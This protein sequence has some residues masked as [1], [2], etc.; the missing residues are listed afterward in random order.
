MRIKKFLSYYN[1]EN[2]ITW[3]WNTETDYVKDTFEYNIKKELESNKKEIIEKIIENNDTDLFKR[4]G[5]EPVEPY[6]LQKDKN[7][8]NNCLLFYFFLYK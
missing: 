4:F 2:F 5:N 1:S 8:I 6:D 3:L 7:I